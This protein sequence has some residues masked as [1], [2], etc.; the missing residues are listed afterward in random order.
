M[1]FSS[2]LASPGGI[3]AY[4]CDSARGWNDPPTFAFS[5]NKANNKPKLDLRKRVSHQQALAGR[6]TPPSAPSAFTVNHEVTE[7]RRLRKHLVF[8]S[9]S[10]FYVIGHKINKCRVNCGNQPFVAV[11]KNNV[12][13]IGLA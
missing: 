4:N 12:K 5:P 10:L 9:L 13:V 2:L 8:H 3:I 6:Q 11:V 7:G 1:M